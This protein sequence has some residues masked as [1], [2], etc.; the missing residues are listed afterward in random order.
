VE[1]A[2]QS[3][4]MGSRADP[5]RS[6]VSILQKA[7]A[8]ELA[9]YLAYEGHWRSLADPS[10][11]AEVREIGREELLHRKRLAVM[12]EELG[13]APAR[14]REVLFRGVGTAIGLFCRVGGWL[15]PMYGAGFLERGNIR[16]Y[17]DAAVLALLA[18]H[19]RFVDCL[20]E[21]AEV[22]WEHEQYFRSKVRGH[23]LG[24][25][26]PLWGPPPP[27]EAIRRPFEAQSRERISS[28]R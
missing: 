9:A 22:E 5:L 27:K 18:G 24:R 11:I 21:M 12:L 4:E 7:H 25:F 10:E 6:L 17:E 2:K 15:A 20:L 16:E 28:T 14:P 26:L 1:A 23:R 13:F 3:I 8:G 19:S